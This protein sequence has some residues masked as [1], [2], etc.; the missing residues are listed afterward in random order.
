MELRVRRAAQGRGPPRGI[1]GGLGRWGR[2]VG[3]VDRRLNVGSGLEGVGT[4]ARLSRSR[5]SQISHGRAY[6]AQCRGGLV[7]ARGRVVRPALV[8]WPK[9]IASRLV[10]SCGRCLRAKGG[11]LGTAAAR[12]RQREALGLRFP[13]LV[14]VPGYISAVPLHLRSTPHP[15]AAQRPSSPQESGYIGT[16]THL[17]SRQGPL[18]TYTLASQVPL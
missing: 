17:P 9:G 5:N 7:D 13:C 8:M 3:L 15:P 2:R 1:K 10:N 16:L 4:C 18:V 11:W 12:N 6:A 14:A